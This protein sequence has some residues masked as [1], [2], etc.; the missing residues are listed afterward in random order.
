MGTI[1]EQITYAPCNLLF[2]AAPRGAFLLI[3]GSNN[4][5]N[6]REKYGLPKLADTTK[7]KN[8]TLAA[9]CSTCSVLA[10]TLLQFGTT[11]SPFKLEQGEIIKIT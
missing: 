1:R 8:D 4:C 9:V 6:A 11:T 2:V 7:T 5:N 10:Q 3:P